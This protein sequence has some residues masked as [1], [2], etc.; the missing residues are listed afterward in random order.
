[1]LFRFLQANLFLIRCIATLCFLP[2]LAAGQPTNDT[3]TISLPQAEQLFI[4]NN[5][6]LLA[7]RFSIDG[8]KANVITAKLYDNPQFGFNSGFYQPDTKK[9]FDY[10]DDNRE[11]ALQLSQLIKTAGKRSKAIELAKTGVQI[12][13]FQF[14]DILR[15]LRYT[16]RNDF[17]NTY[18]LQQM[19][20]AYNLEITSLQKTTLAFEEQ[21][22]KGNIALK[23]LVRVKSQLYS[24]QA[25]LAT[26]QGNIDDVNSEFKLL[27]RAEASA[28]VM[29]LVTMDERPQ[30]IIANVTYQSLLDSAYN[31]RFDLKMAKSTVTFNQQNLLLQK[32]LAVPDVTLNAGYDRLGSYVKGFNAVGFGVNM[33]I[34]NRNQGNIKQAV[35]QTESS[36]L[37]VNAT[38]DAIESQVANSYIGA[39]RAEKLLNSFDPAFEGDFNTL[40]KEVT[41]NYERRNISILEFIDFYDSYK[42]NV[43]Q[44]N[45]LRYN[46]ISQLEQLNFTTGTNI[47]NK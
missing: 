35:A 14:Y 47:F 7:Q 40:I 3:I 38:Q 32:A 9:F 21:V 29:P 16:L 15:S 33:P 44:L 2:G 42:Q 31:N 24:L 4:K 26:L 43:L 45:N 17:Y 20:Q 8:A 12:T 39:V 10:S 11:I 28:Y 36:K 22:K 46:R 27:I 5:L 30:S 6:Q 37:Q 19:Q 25:E 1:M 13:E 41:K 23:E 34:F 18:Y